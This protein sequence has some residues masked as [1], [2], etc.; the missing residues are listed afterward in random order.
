MEEES[1]ASDDEL[2]KEKENLTLAFKADDIRFAFPSAS[3]RVTDDRVF[4][5][6]DMEL[7]YQTLIADSDNDTL[8]LIP[9]DSSGSS[10]DEL[11]LPNATD[12]DSGSCKVSHSFLRTNSDSDDSLR[13][14]ELSKQQA[15][16]IFT[17]RRRACLS[18]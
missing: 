14:L 9:C 11:L 4:D 8:P 6:S 17:R 18:V 10:D 5:D 16:Q 2:L 7:E 1:G 15:Q 13:D 12:S 3:F